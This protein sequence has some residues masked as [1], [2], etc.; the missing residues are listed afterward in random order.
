MYL[1]YTL[2]HIEFE[3]PRFDV[4][5]LALSIMS[6]NL[7]QPLTFSRVHARPL[8]FCTAGEEVILNTVDCRA[9]T[10]QMVCAELYYP[11]AAASLSRQAHLTHIQCKRNTD[12]L[13]SGQSTN[14]FNQQTRMKLILTFKG[15]VLN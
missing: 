14:L 11:A 4:A 10:K 2:A 13:Q 9:H 8:N 12:C 3:Y 6:N 5:A 1:K 15:F 7:K